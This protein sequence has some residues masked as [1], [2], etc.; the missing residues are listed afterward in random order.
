MSVIDLVGLLITFTVACSLFLK[1]FGVILPTKK[2]H[3]RQIINKFYNNRLKI[4]FL[5]QLKYKA[6]TITEECWYNIAK[7]AYI[8]VYNICMQSWKQ[9]ALPVIITMALWQLMHL[10]TWCTVVVITGR[11]HCFHDNIYIY[12]IYHIYIYIYICYIYMI[13]YIW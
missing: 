6:I 9:C 8:I 1:I 13:R 4:Y 5:C 11:A 10:G 2:I 12:I 7:L 3:W